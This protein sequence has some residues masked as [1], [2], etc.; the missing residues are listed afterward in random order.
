[1]SHQS[2]RMNTSY[3]RNGK[4][5]ACEPCR[6][7]KMKCDHMMPTCGRC[8][9]RNRPEQCYYHEAPLTKSYS[10]P[11]PQSSEDTASSVLQSHELD[12]ASVPPIATQSFEPSPQVTR[13]RVYRASSLPAQPWSSSTYSNESIRVPPPADNP[14]WATLSLEQSAGFVYHSAVVAENERS[15]GII[16]RNSG[17]APDWMSNVTQLHIEKGVHPLIFLKD[18]PLYEKYL[19][20]WFSLTRGIILIEPMVKKWSADLWSLHHKVLEAQKPEALF[21]LSEKIWLNTLKPWSV[22]RHTTP[23]E[24]AAMATGENLRWEVVGIIITLVGMLAR[25]LQ[26]EQLFI[27]FIQLQI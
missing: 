9:R 13:P 25:S 10:I 15:L 18:L 20:K 4:L 14:R 8:A 26:G 7:G 23:R 12:N 6:K 5:Q 16:Q 3:R 24:F 17:P 19:D 2:R 11:T 27:S 21:Q 22:N 1:M